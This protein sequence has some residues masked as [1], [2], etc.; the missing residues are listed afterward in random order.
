VSELDVR[1][2]VLEKV[3]RGERVRGV[4]GVAGYGVRTTGAV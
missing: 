4:G 3:E 1:G 2:H